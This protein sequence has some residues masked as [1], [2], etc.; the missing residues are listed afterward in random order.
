MD[1]AEGAYT[2]AMEQE[3]VAIDGFQGASQPCSSDIFRHIIA[4]QNVKVR[5]HL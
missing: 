3:V 4:L 2:L 5:R 1:M